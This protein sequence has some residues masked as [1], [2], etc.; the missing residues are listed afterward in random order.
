MDLGPL[1]FYNERKDTSLVDLGVK[2]QDKR[3]PEL[4]PLPDTLWTRSRRR[5][6]GLGVVHVGVNRMILWTSLFLDEIMA[7]GKYWLG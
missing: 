2:I 6:G 5:I 7:L 1:F 4:T 3:P